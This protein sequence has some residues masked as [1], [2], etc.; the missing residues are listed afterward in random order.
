L[1]D[2]FDS[3][4]IY[5]NKVPNDQVEQVPKLIENKLE[6][7]LPNEKFNKKL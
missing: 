7:L 6:N 2:V 4:E 1:S 5:F 3:I